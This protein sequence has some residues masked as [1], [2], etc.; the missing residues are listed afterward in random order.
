M[1]FNHEQIAKVCHAAN[2]AYCQTLGDDSQTDWDAAPDWQKNSALKGVEF[3]L[4]NLQK[5]IPPQPQA[6]HESW[7]N[8]KVKDGWK[9][10]PVKDAE[11]KEHPC[12]MPFSKLPLDQK[13]KDY[14]FTAIVQ[15]F[16]EAGAKV[17]IVR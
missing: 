6:S 11:K 15:S 16:Y 9:Y 13:M 7:L 4:T 14:I 17:N 2:R 3:H 5:G 1:E 12:F 8:E 10:G